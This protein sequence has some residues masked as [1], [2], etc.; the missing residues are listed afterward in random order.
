MPLYLKS[1]DDINALIA[2]LEFAAIDHET[3]VKIADH[4]VLMPA[5]AREAALSIIVGTL[6]EDEAAF[7]NALFQDTPP[8]EGSPGPGSPGSGSPNTG[9]SSTLDERIGV[10]AIPNGAD[11][12]D[13]V[14]DP[15]FTGPPLPPQC[16]VHRTTGNTSI[17]G[18]DDVIDLLETG[19]TALLTAPVPNG[20]YQLSYRAVAQALSQPFD[21]AVLRYQWSQANGTDLDTRTALI[22]PQIEGDV[23]WARQTQVPALSSTPYL[24][25]SAD[26]T[27]N[28][29]VEAVLINF[30]RL[31]AAYPDA[32]T[33]TLRL[34]GNWYA[35]RGD[36]GINLQFATYL[37]GAMQGPTNEHDF[38]NVGGA[39]VQ[40]INAPRSVEGQVSGDV[41]GDECGTLVYDTATRTAAIV[42]PVPG[43]T[44]TELFEGTPTNPAHIPRSS[45]T[46]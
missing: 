19:F 40:T 32:Q 1:Q 36:G 13:V 25:W 17:I 37:G 28:D 10:V 23:G 8:G 41:D 21:F 39:A 34:R 15:P 44:A 22:A 3:K 9:S 20:G 30:A 18:F 35:A 27:G 45:A 16:S 29:G 43:T 7:A 24:I 26:N 14:F 5:S 46:K 4:F 42:A 31:R 6:P 12:V 38:V 11:R 2:G 33:I